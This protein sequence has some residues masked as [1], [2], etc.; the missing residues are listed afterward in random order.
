MAFKIRKSDDVKAINETNLSWKSSLSSTNF[1]GQFTNPIIMRAL[2]IVKLCENSFASNLL[3]YCND[4]S[5]MESIVIEI[6]L[7][8]CWNAFVKL[9]QKCLFDPLKIFQ[10]HCLSVRNMFNMKIHSVYEVAIY[11]IASYHILMIMHSEYCA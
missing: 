6:R 9:V 2:W 10:I 3:E 8:E 11:F 4:F 7:S 5:R 1:F